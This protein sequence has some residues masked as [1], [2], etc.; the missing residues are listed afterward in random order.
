MTV[1]DPMRGSCSSNICRE[2]SPLWFRSAPNGVRAEGASNCSP[3]DVSAS[4]QLRRRKEA[5]A[6]T[7]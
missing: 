1:R 2:V 3:G 4:C 5:Q 7:R 6:K